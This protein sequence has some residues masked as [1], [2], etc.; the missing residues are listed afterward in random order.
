MGTGAGGFDGGVAADLFGS[1]LL[2]LSVGGFD[3]S[4]NFGRARARYRLV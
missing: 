1:A 4:S 3:V 2:G